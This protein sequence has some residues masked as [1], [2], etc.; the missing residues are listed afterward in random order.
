VASLTISTTCSHRSRLFRYAKVIRDT[1]ERAA[2]LTAQLLAFSRR[3]MLKMEVLNLN[4]VI[5][6]MKEM[7]GRLI[8]EDIELTTLLDSDKGQIEQVIMNL[9]LNV[10]DAI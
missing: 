3:Q 10:R 4:L 8:G 1:A 6:D 5:S 2:S 9:V 7:L